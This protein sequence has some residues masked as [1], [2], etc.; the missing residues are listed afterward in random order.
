MELNLSHSELYSAHIIFCFFIPQSNAFYTLVDRLDSLKNNSDHILPCSEI[1]IGSQELTKQS[2]K[3]WNLPPLVSALP[4]SLYSFPSRLL[5]FQLNWTVG[6][7][8]VLFYGAS[9]W[10]SGKESV[11]NA[12]D[13]GF[14]PGSGRSPGGRNENPLQFLSGKSH[15][16]RSLAGAYS[17]WSRK[18]VGHNFVTKQQ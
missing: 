16:Q 7:S 12:G 15:G 14:V 9:W 8:L 17:P 5:M 18:R 3:S 2:P 4:T 11:C 10:L 13:T 1:S 6:F